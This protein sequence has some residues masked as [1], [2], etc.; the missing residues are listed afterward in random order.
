MSVC[1]MLLCDVSVAGLPTAIEN[2]SPVGYI[3][4]SGHYQKGGN[5]IIQ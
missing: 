1:A 3:N 5:A 4:A 2:P